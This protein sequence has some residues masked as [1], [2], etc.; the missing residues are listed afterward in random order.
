MCRHYDKQKLNG[1]RYIMTSD[2]KHTLCFVCEKLWATTKLK[3]PSTWSLEHWEARDGC[4]WQENVECMERYCGITVDIG[5][6]DPKITAKVAK[7]F[8][9]PVPV[10]PVEP[11]A[12]PKR[13]VPVPASELDNSRK[14]IAQAMLEHKP[15]ANCFLEPE[16]KMVKPTPAAVDKELKRLLQIYMAAAATK[17]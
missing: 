15:P 2:K 4:G 10:T 17:A 6:R 14:T 16:V 13:A 9:D 12:T 7:W 3:N 11:R 5:E 8:N 1:D